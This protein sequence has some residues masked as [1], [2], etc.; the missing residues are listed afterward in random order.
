MSDEKQK[1]RERIR[2]LLAMTYARGCT[3]AE[4][5][6]A[7]EKAAKLM[8]DNGLSVNDIE[9]EERSSLSRTASKGAK[10]KLW[11]VIA[12][13]TNTACVAVT[14]M[15][16][17]EV[18]FVGREPGPQVAV[19]LRTVCE[20]AIDREVATFKCGKFYRQRRNVSTRRHAVADFTAALVGRLSA[21]LMTL[22]EQTSSEAAIAEANAALDERYP[23]A[24]SV[25]RRAHKERYFDAGMAGRRAGDKVHLAHGLSSGQTTIA[26]I[27][28]AA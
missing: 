6:A 9:M 13:C 20:R 23:D 15:G 4:A 22:F 11:P 27:G 24:V 26:Q 12:H 28:G 8:R 5:I 18:H 3:E 14:S 2:R 7:A 19:Y 17:H 25:R 1:A 21:R 16:R 10:A